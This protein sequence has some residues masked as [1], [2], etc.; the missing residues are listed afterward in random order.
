MF[1]WWLGLAIGVAVVVVVVVV[2]AVI[3]VMAR[4]IGNQAQEAVRA[5]D[6]GR[7]NTRALWDLQ[8]INQSAGG[9]LEAAK[10]ARGA[11][12]G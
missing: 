9:I 2:V 12:G 11:L 5:L 4:R 10:A 3:L 8:E 6:E 1:G 7:T